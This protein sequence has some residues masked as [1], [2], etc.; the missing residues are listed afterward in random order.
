MEVKFRS[1]S[2]SVASC[3]YK[4]LY[5]PL[6]PAFKPARPLL[7]CCEKMSREHVGSLWMHHIKFDVERKKGEALS[8]KGSL[9]WLSL[10]FRRVS[11]LSEEEEGTSAL[12]WSLKIWEPSLWVPLLQNLR[13]KQRNK[14]WQGNWACFTDIR[15]SLIWNVMILPMVGKKVS[16]DLSYFRSICTW[17]N[18]LP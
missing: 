6:A 17:C 14:A 3:S 10:H 11:Y 4:Y 5:L 16:T 8:V 9:R 15:W 18:F 1:D 13:P 12:G 7:P 2:E